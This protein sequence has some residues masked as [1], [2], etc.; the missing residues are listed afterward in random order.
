MTIVRPL[1]LCMLLLLPGCASVGKL[2]SRSSHDKA[3]ASAEKLVQQA[4]AE[5]AA[6]QTDAALTH[7]GDARELDPL[8]SDM[9]DRIEH[10][11]ERCAETRIVEL[12]APGGDPDDM[13]DLFDLRLPRQL[14]ITAGVHAARL[15]LER[16]E[17]IKAFAM[18]QKVDT[19]YPPAGTHHER[20]MAGDILFEAG[21]KL[22]Q[23][24]FSI[25][26]LFSDADDAK[27][28]LEYL[29][30][31]YPRE[32]RCDQAYNRLAQLY[33]D[34]RIWA[35]AI[36]R[37]QDLVTY[38]LDSPLAVESEW[39]IPH[40]RLVALRRPE[41]DRRELLRTLSELEAWL[42]AHAAHELESKVVVDRRDCLSRLALSDLG[43]VKFYKQ[44]H[45][46]EGAR[47]HAER[48]LDFAKLGGDPRLIAQA[49][50]AIAGLPPAEAHTPTVPAVRDATAPTSP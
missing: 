31:N 44:V 30:Q 6:G 47:L 43:V 24:S 11:L 18:I 26:G 33:E 45:K 17:E 7:L 50:R 46:W 4:S 9:K 29:V 23:S 2:F 49:T 10:L 41:Y 3:E 28:I 36:E 14:A 32:R 48:A 13:E 1:L 16:G 40:L 19:R 42:E 34:D 25:L 20:V 35:T 21:M 22:S 37:Y 38:H 8:P 5:M 15:Q 39:R 12:S 27:G